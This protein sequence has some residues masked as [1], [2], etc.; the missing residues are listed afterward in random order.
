[1]TDFDCHPKW[2]QLVY[3]KDLRQK[4]EEHLFDKC[5]THAK[6]KLDYFNYLVNNLN[7]PKKEALNVLRITYADL[8]NY[9]NLIEIVDKKKRG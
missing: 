9:K 8:E 6:E 7:I 1:M 2:D 5:V 4:Y 3:D